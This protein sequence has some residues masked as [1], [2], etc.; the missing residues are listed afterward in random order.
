MSK[1]IVDQDVC[2]GCGAC[3]AT[4]STAFRLVPSE[5]G[6]EVSEVVEGADFS[7]PCVEEAVIGCPVGAISTE[8]GEE[9]D[10]VSLEEI[11][12]DEFESGDNDDDL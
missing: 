3:A 9:D 12:E 5:N 8:G 7:A 1:P 10:V 4:C 2:V 6:G 11:A